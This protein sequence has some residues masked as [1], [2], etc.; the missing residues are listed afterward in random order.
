[1]QPI[2][3]LIAI[4]DAAMILAVVVIMFR[5]ENAGPAK[6]GHRRQS[7]RLTEPQ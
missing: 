4:L 7:S 6:P 1:M 3:W 5:E 2:A